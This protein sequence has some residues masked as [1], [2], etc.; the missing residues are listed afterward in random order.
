MPCI[1]D[2][3]YKQNKQNYLKDV[4]DQ[5]FALVRDKRLSD[6]VLNLTIYSR[7]HRNVKRDAPIVEVQSKKETVV[8]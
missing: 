7:G 8:V 4:H 1:T 6:D 2:P 5:V 3:T